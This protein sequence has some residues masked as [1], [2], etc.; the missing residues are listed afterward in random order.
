MHINK[1]VSQQLQYLKLFKKFKVS[2][3]HKADF[4][5]HGDDTVESLKKQIT[6][7]INQMDLYLREFFHSQGYFSWN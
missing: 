4:N 2:C 3:R 7:Y 5:H 1:L 6:F